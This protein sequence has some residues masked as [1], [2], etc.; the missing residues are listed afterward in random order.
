MVTHPVTFT[1]TRLGINF[2]T[3]AAGSIRVGLLNRD[4]LPIAGFETN[5]CMPLIG[6]HLKQVVRWQDTADLSSV[7]AQPIRLVFEMQ[8]ADL[9]SLQFTP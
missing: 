6:D 9:Y 2:S 4:G 7:Q 8:D 1:G 5:R 3:S